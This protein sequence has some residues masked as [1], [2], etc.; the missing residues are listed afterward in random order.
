VSDRWSGPFPSENVAGVECAALALLVLV[1][2][3][4]IPL[5]LAWRRALIGFGAVA[6]VLALVGLAASG[7]R[8]GVLALVVGVAVLVGL[9]A[10][11]WRL[12]AGA[13]GVVALA[14]LVAPL[15]SRMVAGVVVD[16]SIADRLRLWWATLA[17]IADHPWRG[18]PTSNPPDWIDAWYLPAVL[19]GRFASP[20]NAILDTALTYGLPVAGTAMILIAWPLALAAD[21][22]MRG[23]RLVAGCAALA[24]AHLTGAMFQSHQRWWPYALVLVLALI[25]TALA[26]VARPQARSERMGRAAWHALAAGA[27]ATC[28][29]A[30]LALLAAHL[31]PWQAHR[32]DGVVL[33]RPR[34]TEPWAV[35]AIATDHPTELARTGV[36]WAH[37]ALADGAEVVLV[38]RG[39]D[40]LAAVVADRG[41]FRPVSAVG[42]GEAGS[43]VWRGDVLLGDRV[44]GVAVDPTALADAVSGR[45]LVITARA[46]PFVPTRAL[47]ARVNVA[48]ER[49]VILPT[50]RVDPAAGW[51]L[52]AAALRQH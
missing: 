42:F 46:A 3:A 34:H 31:H 44:L 41:D 38:E 28:V 4:A 49:I 11:G 18:V 40:A 36:A 24:M 17:C 19:G 43:R 45:R 13:L 39:W 32:V 9:R 29:L 52:V 6:T 7:S 30:A 51:A 21:P 2:I 50:A 20:L 27:L 47:R 10:I 12:A 16:A 23:Q 8:A 1:G 22:R 14:S 26:A 5:G 48:N 37:A 15:G 35:I 25:G 33:V